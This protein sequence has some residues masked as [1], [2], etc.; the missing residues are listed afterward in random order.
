[1]LFRIGPLFNFD[2]SAV[3]LLLLPPDVN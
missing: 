1:L 3:H 2:V